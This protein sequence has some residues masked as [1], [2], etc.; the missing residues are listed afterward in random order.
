MFVA[1]SPWSVP[2]GTL[3]SLA[4]KSE[5]LSGGHLR[6]VCFSAALQAEGEPAR[7]GQALEQELAVVLEQHAQAKGFSDGLRESDRVGFGG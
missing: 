6:E 7:Y 2:P 3:E 1:F 4:R 5:G